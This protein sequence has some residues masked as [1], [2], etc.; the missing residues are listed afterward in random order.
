MTDRQTVKG[1]FKEEGGL[2]AWTREMNRVFVPLSLVAYGT[3]L[4]TI[5]GYWKIFPAL[6]C[7]NQLFYQIHR[8]FQSS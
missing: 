2:T 1:T 6:L 8:N 4:I 5:P 7:L 3:L